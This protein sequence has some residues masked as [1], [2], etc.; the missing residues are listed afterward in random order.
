MNKNYPS[1]HRIY[2]HHKGGLYEVIILAINASNDGKSEQTVVYKSVEFGT[3]YTRPLSEWNESV[4]VKDN[5]ASFFSGE[6][7]FEKC[8]RFKIV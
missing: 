2:E 7:V 5:R 3:V 1:L 6:D 8:P 4:E